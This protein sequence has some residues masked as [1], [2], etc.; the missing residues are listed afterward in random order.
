MPVKGQTNIVFGN[1]VIDHYPSINVEDR[2]VDFI[3][4]RGMIRQNWGS[5]PREFFWALGGFRR[6]EI[7]GEVVLYG[8]LGK[9]RSSHIGEFYDAKQHDFFPGVVDDRDMLSIASFVIDIRRM[10]IVFEEKIQFISVRSFIK[11]FIEMYNN[12]FVEFGNVHIFMESDDSELEK[13]FKLTKKIVKA[14]FNNLKPSN[15]SLTRNWEKLDESMRQGR[16]KTA[17]IILKNDEEGLSTEGELLQMGIAAC[18]D[19]YGKYVI[20]GLDEN[21]RPRKHDVKHP[22]LRKIVVLPSEPAE[23]INMLWEELKVFV[24]EKGKR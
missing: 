12:M 9:K 10:I 11:A 8:R 17:D 21:D 13:F 1:L 23:I 4:N 18:D 20:T 5:M 24:Q 16:I 22:L 19:G 2:L 6:L 7:D 14:R 15:P 3:K